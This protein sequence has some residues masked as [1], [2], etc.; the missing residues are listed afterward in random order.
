M[1]IIITGI[2]R[3]LRALGSAAEND[4][5]KIAG[6]L[7]QSAQM[8]YKR[9]QKYVPVDTEA[10]KKSGRVTNNG[11]K[12]FGARS[13]VEYGGPGAPHAMVVH[14]RTEVPHASPTCAKYLERASRELRGSITALLRQRMLVMGANSTRVRDYV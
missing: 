2:E 7:D 14:E 11:K 12:G 3:T 4:G 10:L 13:A 1:P 5:R 8:I 9:S 6:V